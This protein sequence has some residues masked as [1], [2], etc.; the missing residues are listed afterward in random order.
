MIPDFKNAK[1]TVSAFRNA[2]D[3]AT[4]E[5]ATS[6]VCINH[7]HPNHQ[8]RGVLPFYEL[9]G[10]TALADTVWSPLKI[11]MPIMQRRMDI[12]FCGYHDITFNNSIWVIEMGKILGD[13][14]SHWLN[15]PATGKT[16][17]LPYTSLYKI[18]NSLISETVEFLDIFSV[19]TQAGLNPFINNQTGAHILSPGPKTNDGIVTSTTDQAET[20]KTYDLTIRMLTE[21]A[22]SY[23]SS[24]NHLARHWHSDMNWFGPTGIGT[25]FGFSGYQRGHT[26]PFEKKLD[27]VEIHD[28]EL[29]VAEGHFS[30]VMWWPC[31]TMRNIDNYM[32]VP[33]NNALTEMRVVDLY[34]RE[35]DKLAE[36][37]IFIDMLHF[38][39]MQGINLLS[40]IGE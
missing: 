31:L 40:K 34:R 21:L 27:M 39:K 11:A 12:L 35:G 5:D 3:N 16:V 17:Y 28:W 22:E 33:A 18:E 30:A 1:A 10:P 8:Y 19:I 2:L 13:F 38:L 25:S 9:L 32:G 24:T 15:I 26:G 29:A 6:R 14:T 36:N 4:P 7:L 20:K 23:T 37:W